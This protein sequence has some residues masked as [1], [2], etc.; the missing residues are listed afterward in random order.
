MDIGNQIVVLLEYLCKKQKNNKK[1]QC[2][3]SYK[4]FKKGQASWDMRSH[5]KKCSDGHYFWIID[6]NK[7]LGL[8]LTGS[9]F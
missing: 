7:R 1:I 5:P 9:V 4:T 8:I 2:I 3:D 6:T